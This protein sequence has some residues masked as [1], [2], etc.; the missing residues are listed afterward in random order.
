[1]ITEVILIFISALGHNVLTYVTLVVLIFICTFTYKIAANVTFVIARICV[2]AYT[3]Y[4]LAAPVA[5]VVAVY[6]DA[7]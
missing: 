2:H 1:M 4:D 5:L 7:M 6:I 3:C